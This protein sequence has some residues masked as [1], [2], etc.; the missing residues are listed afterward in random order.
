VQGYERRKRQQQRR[1]QWQQH[2]HKQ[3]EQLTHFYEFSDGAGAAQEALTGQV[4]EQGERLSAC[5]SRMERG[6]EFL[7]RL[8][9]CEVRLESYEKMFTALFKEFIEK[10]LSA[11]DKST[12]KKEEMAD[13]K[14][15]ED[16]KAAKEDEI[17]AG[18]GQIDA[19]TKELSDADEKNAQTKENAQSKTEAQNG[20]RVIA[21]ADDK[22]IPTQELDKAAVD[23]VQTELVRDAVADDPRLTIA[24]LYGPLVQDFAKAIADKESANADAE[25]EGQFNIDDVEASL[26]QFRARWELRNEV[27]ALIQSYKD[28]DLERPQ[29]AG[30]LDP[31]LQHAAQQTYDV[32]YEENQGHNAVLE[33]KTLAE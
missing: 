13:Q 1:R 29:P 8:Q 33:S 31:R 28:Q 2:E 14:A 22:T 18:Q 17:K 26:K 4:E 6:G 9:A 16:L 20:L 11:Q 24:D 5:E 7:E 23:Q 15:Y 12:D 30:K 3:G 10:G 25:S 32:M 27:E 21:T 19:K